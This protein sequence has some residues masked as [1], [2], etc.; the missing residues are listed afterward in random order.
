M[1]HSQPFVEPKNW[2]ERQCLAYDHS[3]FGALAALATAQSCWGAIAAIMSLYADTFFLLGIASFLC[4]GS[5]TAFLSQAPAKW[6]IGVFWLSAVVNA[7]IILINAI[8]LI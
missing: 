6:A 1:G 4:M 2:F 3:T 5:L 7:I 8:I